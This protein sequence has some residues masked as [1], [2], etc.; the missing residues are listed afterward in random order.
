[1]KKVFAAVVLSLVFVLSIGV[2]LVIAQQD[3]PPIPIDPS[4]NLQQPITATVSSSVE[5]TTD[6]IELKLQSGAFDPLVSVPNLPANLSLTAYAAD[7]AG[8]YLVQFTGPI[9]P[10]WKMALEKMGA[11]VLDYVPQFAYI[12][13]MNKATAD[14]LSSLPEVRWVGLYQPAYRLS[15]A[16]DKP[17][18]M[19]LPGKTTQVVVR[20][21]TGES[22]SRM[23]VQLETLGASII[24]EAQDSGGGAQFKIELPT[25][26]LAS[27]AN[28]GGVAWIEPWVPYT[29]TNSIARSNLIMKKDL[30]EQ[31]LSLYGASQIVVVGDTGVS[32]GN[33]ATINADFAG[34][35]FTGTTG[36]ASTCHNWTDANEH[37]THVAGSVLGSG[38][39][40]GAVTTTH[41]YAG[42]QA[43]IAPEAQL[44]AWGVCNDFSG[45]PADLYTNYF[46]TMYNV[47]PRVRLNTN[48]WGASVYGQ[49]TI[50][51]RNAD[52]FIWEHPD[53]TVLFAASN[54]GIDANGDGMIDPDSIGA[55]GTAKNVITVGASEN[56]R[57][58]GGYNPGGPCS[59]WGT[60][61]PS[62]Y[63]ANPV[64]DDPLSNNVSGMVAFSSRGPTDDGRLKP[65]IVA[66]GSNIVSVRYEGTG[67]GWGVYDSHYLY[68]G[69]TSM[70]TPLAAGATAIVREFY[71]V[72]YS[73][74]NP[75]AALLKATLINGAADMT[76]GQYRTA[77]PDGSKDDVTRRPDNNQGWGRVDLANSLIYD[78]PRQLWFYQHPTGLGTNQ[79][80][81]ATFSVLDNQHP[82]RVSLAWSDYP[83]TEAAGGGLVNDL[84]LRVVAPG[85]GVYYGN[86]I[87][88][89]GLLD[90]DRDHL[91]NVEGVDFGQPLL[92][93]Y[94]VYVKGYNVPQGPQLFALVVSGDLQGNVG[95]LT[96]QIKNATNLLPISDATVTA[97]S[98]T[99]TLS[100]KSDATGQ[101]W[102]PIYAGTYT[103]T[104]AA[105]GYQSNTVLGVSVATSLTTTQDITLTPLST[106]IVSGTVRDAT[107]NWPLYASVNITPYPSGAIWTDPV[108]GFYTVTLP[109][110]SAVTFSVAAWTPGYIT[111]SRTFTVTGNRTENFNLSIDALSCTAPE[112]QLSSATMLTESFDTITSFP[113]GNWD[114]VDISGTTGNW[115]T[116]TNTVHPANG[117]T[118]S[119]ARLAYFNSWTATSGRA[120]RLYRTVGLNL[121]SYTTAQVAVWVYH[122][123]QYSNADTIQAQISTN[124]G[125]VWNSVG[126]AINRYDGSA[127][128]KQ[129][130]IDLSSYT[131]ASMTDVRI[132]FLGT[133]NYGNDTHIDDVTVTA[134]TCT[135][136]NGGLVVGNVYDA[137][138][139]TPLSGATVAKAGGTTT[140]DVNGFYTLFSPSGSRTFTATMTGYIPGVTTT[141]VVQSTT[142]RVD[143]YLPFN[144]TGYTWTGNTD[145]NWFVAANW[146]PAAVPTTTGSVVIPT[147]PVGNRWPI[148]TGTATVNDLTL[149]SGAVLTVSQGI[150]LY[151]N[152]LVANN[153][154]LAQIKDVPASATTEFLRITDASGTIDKYHGVDLTPGTTAMGVTAVQIKGNQSACTTV[155]GDPIIHRC[156]RI[157]PTTQ[158]SATVRFW[159]TEAERNAQPANT[160]KLWHWGPWAQVGGAGNYTYS[161][162][163]AAC[164]SGGGQ[165]C[166]FQSTGVASYSPFALGSGSAP[167]ALRLIQI[168]GRSSTALPL[169]LLAAA[170]ALGLSMSLIIL[171][172]RRA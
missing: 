48:S 107:T 149:Q 121:S 28:L 99:R 8:Y 58:T 20:A 63:P 2:T 106:Y 164:T 122:D 89:D 23:R 52:R 118:H 97:S 29:V 7:G 169:L 126:T 67:T 80:Y 145:T 161:E 53:M 165:A 103:V 6:S 148:L 166:W 127:G 159:F 114:Q 124:G 142:Q 119:G 87:V 31:R 160:L 74:T 16:L 104:A 147:A 136:Q 115:A 134:S 110:N 39:N 54:D 73:I 5:P 151:V 21:F 158:T 100:T 72:T 40:S 98:V 69:G 131:G 43:G 154:S 81:S 144:T 61:W 26:A 66:P 83:G 24:A 71:S 64:K 153:G 135:L 76:P 123:T 138:T 13:R 79:E 155:P 171:K 14:Q 46:G 168:D 41:S 1:M 111:T 36:P 49:Y 32:T 96:G 56:Q 38:V 70:A 117:G 113:S 129:H 9:F 163:G 75:T 156:Y 4:A 37:G 94:V 34:R 128:W 102:M 146:N 170:I 140:T 137:S 86:D 109:E 105:Y 84:D 3:Q 10:E 19:A 50:D 88:G 108:T 68:M 91:N 35:I 27:A 133:S 116:S 101:Y 22:G 77:V 172:R 132:A 45:L 15:T 93:Q 65:D 90:G 30:V 150:T 12:V 82:F 143:F 152:G 92:G 141:N 25:T 95:Y 139:L 47:D 112:H 18:N 162:G 44:F 167:T 55:P 33:P 11:T 42:T 17:M 60:C 85:G 51:S 59:T 62:D 157:D 78:A 57:A 120:T 125:T 130:T